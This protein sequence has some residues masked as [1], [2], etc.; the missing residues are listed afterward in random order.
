MCL[1][2]ALLIL[3]N[4]SQNINRIDDSLRVLKMYGSLLD[5]FITLQL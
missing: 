2:I 1:K 4:F 5:D 3:L